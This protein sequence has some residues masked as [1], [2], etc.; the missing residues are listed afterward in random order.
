[1]WAKL[2]P[3]AIRLVMILL[4]A[5]IAFF[6]G[7][8]HYAASAAEARTEAVLEATAQ[9]EARM[10]DALE[11]ASVRARA[12]LDTVEKLRADLRERERI[13]ERYAASESGS[14]ICLDPEGMEAW[15]AL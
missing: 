8:Y 11:R 7:R 14:E 13:V 10:Q 1:M 5:V 2:L 15:N 6:T 9:A 12:H 4:V 3:Y